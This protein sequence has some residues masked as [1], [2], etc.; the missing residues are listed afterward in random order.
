MTINKEVTLNYY[1]GLNGTVFFDNNSVEYTY[2]HENDGYFKAK[3]L[4]DILG[5][6]K[7]TIP[8]NLIQYKEF[9]NLHTRI[10]D[11]LYDMEDSIKTDY[12]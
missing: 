9:N 11:F 7:G 10:Q 4:E 8:I 3:Y 2:I 12:I 5:V 1:D 6:L